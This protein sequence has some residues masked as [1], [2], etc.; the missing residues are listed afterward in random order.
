MQTVSDIG[1]FALIEQ[2]AQRLGSS[3]NAHVVVG[4]GDDA[5]VVQV[6]GASVVSCV[7]IFIQGVH[8]R[9][10]WS[11]A[12]DIGRKVIAANLADIVAMGATPTSLLVGLAIPASTEVSW[13]L[14]LADGMKTEADVLGATV[15]GGDI[16]RSEHI[17]ISVTAL[18]DLRG[19]QPVL[20]SG[21][22]VGDV[23][24]VAGQLGYAG[25]GLMLLS[26]GFRSP[27][28]IVSMHRVPQPPYEQALAAT[29]AHSMIDTSDG[30]LADVGHIADASGVAI[31]IASN[32]IPIA[33]ELQSVAS[34]FNEDVLKLVLGSGEDHAF[35]ATFA[36]SSDMPDGWT[37]IG[38]VIQG[39][40][41]TVDGEAV[42]TT[43]WQHFSA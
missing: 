42:E 8:F 9:L 28:S 2:I 24:A 21:A 30:L 39:S 41:V 14:E 19:K 36:S 17:M 32:S 31:D 6:E 33:E 26:R 29:K 22:K 5:A 37:V 3:P 1:E 12:Q 16:A 7:D 13:V 18:G 25:A 34:A 23:V 38:S 11:S 20:R 4:P 15:V 35:V 40:G 10:D 43:G 27:R